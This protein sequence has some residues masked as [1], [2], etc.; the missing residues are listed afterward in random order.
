[1][2][3]NGLVEVEIA[4]SAEHIRL[5]RPEIMQYE[6]ET[7]TEDVKINST[8]AEASPKKAKKPAAEPVAEP[9]PEPKAV[10]FTATMVGT[11]RRAAPGGEPFV[12]VGKEVNPKTVLCVI[13]AMSVPNGIP[14]KVSGT[15]TEILAEDGQSVEYGTP[16][17]RVAISPKKG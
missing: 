8:T 12:E 15:I 1:M 17:F 4:D 11:F 9:E 7:E 3:E 5:R 10:D 2:D 13:E 6:I 16:L 14:A